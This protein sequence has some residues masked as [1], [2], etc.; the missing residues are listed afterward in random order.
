[1][2]DRDSIKYVEDTSGEDVFKR[3]SLY[4][5][6][7][8]IT[9]EECDGK[10][11]VSGTRRIEFRYEY[12]VDTYSHVSDKKTAIPYIKYLYTRGVDF[13][14]DYDRLLKDGCSL[15]AN[16]CASRKYAEVVSNTSGVVMVSLNYYQSIAF[17]TK[18]K[19][20]K[21]KWFTTMNSLIRKINKYNKSGR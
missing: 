1:M 9:V 5:N 16:I 10:I 21:K 20:N 4:W 12:C 17:S 6:H 18:H 15:L 13:D 14:N 11:I 3:A 7:Q 19:G 8:T 2:S